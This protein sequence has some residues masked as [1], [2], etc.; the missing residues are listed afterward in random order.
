MDV[1]LDNCATTPVDTRVLAALQ[2]WL[3]EGW[4]NASAHGY[5]LAWDAQRA[6]E[7][8]RY[9]MARSIN[10]VPAS[11]I[12]TSG[13]TESLSTV[14]RG[15]VGYQDW[16]RCKL[17]T[18]ATEHAAVLQSCRHMRRMTGLELV[19]LDLDRNG[20]C[21]LD[22]VRAAARSDKRTLVSAMAANNETGT[23][24]PVD[25]IC[26]VSQEAGA[27][28]L[29][30]LTQAVGK[31]QV[32]I[33]RSNFDFAA[34][35][36]H[37][38]YG[39]KGVGALVIREG[40]KF[41]PLIVGGGQERG[42]RGGTLNV[43]GIVGFGEACRI[44]KEEMESDNQRIVQLRDRLEATLMTELP[45]IWINGAGAE[46]LCNTSNIGFR[47]VDARTMIR[48]MHDIACST[49]SA[50]SS[51]DSRPSHVLKAIGLTDDE[52][53][54]CIRFSL[55][56]FT[57][58]QEIDYAL[59]KIIGSVRKLRRIAGSAGMNPTRRST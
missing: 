17:V 59:E 24:L 22:E 55:G 48:D 8:A 21:D 52:A 15:V 18:L 54:S 29:C 47:G 31:L 44:A 25:E 6:I 35:S 10:Q 30:D 5:R 20:V 40:E 45:D 23:I 11:V 12:F 9:E 42:L 13:A 57:T 37:K 39:P 53:Y 27:S 28:F 3:S 4:G 1:F 51:G 32:D 7:D 14:I 50:C 26:Q 56:R 34:F 16:E 33:S 46:R 58:E 36:S 38:I 43:P 41:E 19:I 2:L 49:K